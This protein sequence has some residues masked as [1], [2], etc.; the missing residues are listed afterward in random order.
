MNKQQSH[1]ARLSNYSVLWQLLERRR[2]ETL[3]DVQQRLRDAREEWTRTHETSDAGDNSE[4]DGREDI[5]LELIR[6]KARTLHQINDAIS[7]I[8]NGTYGVCVDCRHRIP[9]RRLRALPFAARCKKCEE[10]RETTERTAS[11]VNAI[12]R[13]V[14]DAS[15]WRPDSTLRRFE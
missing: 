9:E 2:Q 4:L 15:E 1:G 3:N 5:E 10:A 12:S 8:H 6:M 7:R 11:P 14:V 13:P